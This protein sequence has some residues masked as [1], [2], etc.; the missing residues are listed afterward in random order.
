VNPASNY[1][2]RWSAGTHSWRHK[3]EGGFD[4]SRYEVA[5]IPDDAAAKSF[6][7][8]HHYSRS[9]PAARVRAGLYEGG[10]LVG[11][12][13]FGIPMQQ[14]VL[15]RAFPRLEP[16]EESLELS[17]FVLLDQVPANAETWFLARAF[18]EAAQLGVRGVVS[19]A[20]P[21]PRVTRDGRV[22]SPGHTGVIYQASNGLFTADRGTP[23]TLLLGP[24]GLVLSDRAMSK[25]RS[26]ERGHVYAEKQ[27]VTWGARP[28]VAGENPAAWLQQALI[29][30]DVTRL[31]HPGNYRY[32]FRLGRT[33]GERTRVVVGMS[34]APYPKKVAA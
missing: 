5:L 6:V 19:F 9:Y 15:T 22:L 23:R 30:A 14:A 24:D 1:C 27:L 20:D 2:Q 28:M 7:V 32:L 25:I 3:S 21:V 10:E 16:Y 33:R 26:Q 34:S 29:Q 4:S 12:G 31:R 18:G 13:V 11:V 8:R 17:R